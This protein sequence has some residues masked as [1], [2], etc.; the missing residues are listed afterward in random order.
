MMPAWIPFR[1]RKG[2]A[3]HFLARYCI[4]VCICCNVTFP[5]YIQAALADFLFFFSGG[6]TRCNFLIVTGLGGI[7]VC[8]HSVEA[9][10]RARCLNG[11]V[12]R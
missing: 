11:A 10:F 8:I 1:A 2:L 7:A 12:F 4:L 5:L 3:A 6:E 9:V